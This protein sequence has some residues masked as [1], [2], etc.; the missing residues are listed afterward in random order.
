MPKKKSPEFGTVE[1]YQEHI[2]DGTVWKFEGSV[3][4]AAMDLLRSG[5]CELGEKPCY[6]YY[7]NRVPSRFEVKAGTT[8]AP[9]STR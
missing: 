5:Q 7:G 9:L 6:D 1:W 8:G 2:N 3:G 4:R